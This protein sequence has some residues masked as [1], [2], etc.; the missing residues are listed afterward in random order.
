MKLFV[1][2][3][4]SRS[5]AEALREAGHDVEYAGDL[6]SAYPD[7]DLLQH[8]LATQQIILT[9]DFD[10]GDL[11]MRDRNPAKGIIIV[12]LPHDLDDVRIPRI[13]DALAEIGSTASGHLTIIETERIRQRP[14]P[15]P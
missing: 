8:A 9:L 2:E 7:I 15:A 5:L 1:D 11:V 12:Y 10:F 3:C 4:C 14:L 13:R 6:F